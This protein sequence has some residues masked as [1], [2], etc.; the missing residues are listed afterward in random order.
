MGAGGIGCA[1]GRR[2]EQR[3]VLALALTIPALQRTLEHFG[4]SGISGVGEAIAIVAGGE[5][6]GVRIAIE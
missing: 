4:S 2:L 1:E 5:R 3:S 6:S